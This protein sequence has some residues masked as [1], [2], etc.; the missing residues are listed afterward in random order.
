MP[1]KGF[2]TITVSEKDYAVLEFL[3]LKSRC[4]ISEIVSSWLE[5]V[6]KVVY[7]LEFASHINYLFAVNDRGDKVVCYFG[8]MTLE[9]HSEHSALGEKTNEILDEKLEEL[10]NENFA[11]GIIKARQ[12]TRKLVEESKKKV[13]A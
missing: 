8:A 10:S 11:N 7:P 4:P 2:K 5:E 13:K 6:A 1:N 9:K 3:S 12:E